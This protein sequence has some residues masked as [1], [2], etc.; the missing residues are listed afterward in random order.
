M[1]NNSFD[2]SDVPLWFSSLPS[3]TSL[4]ASLSLSLS[5][6]HTNSWSLYVLQDMFTVLYKNILTTSLQKLQIP[7]VPENR[8]G[9]APD[10]VQQFST[11]NS[12]SI[13]WFQSLTQALSNLQIQI[14][15]CKKIAWG[16]ILNFI[17]CWLYRKLRDNRFN[18]TLNIGT[19]YS[20][21]LQLIDLTNNKIDSLTVGGG[22]TK[23]LM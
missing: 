13:L 10:S 22:Y 12:V 20:N 21:Q 1:S 5:L 7:W 8:R 19:A 15:S 18:G 6:T 4:Y 23:Q 16:L 9:V 14:S 11:S 3:L 2:S 17:I